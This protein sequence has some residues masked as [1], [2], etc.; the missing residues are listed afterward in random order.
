MRIKINKL[1]NNAYMPVRKNYNDAGADVAIMKRVVLRPNEVQRV[2]LG[3]SI[4]IPDGFT[5]LLMS[6]S[7]LTVKGCVS[8]YTPI[9]SGYR[10]EVSVVLH[11]TQNTYCIFE[12][13]DRVCQLVIMPII[14]AEFV[15]ELENTRQSGGFGSTGLNDAK[16]RPKTWLGFY[17]SKGEVDCKA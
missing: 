9:D 7:S 16:K 14:L 8:L 6:R 15:T 5:G 10:G 12:R 1:N 13:G 2:P 11:N 3:W 17:G 4:E